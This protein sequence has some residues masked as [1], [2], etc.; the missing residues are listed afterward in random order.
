MNSCYIPIM[1]SILGFCLFFILSSSVL[2]QSQPQ[3]LK[4]KLDS[5][6]AHFSPKEPG[7]SILIRE[8][9]KIIYQKSFGLEDLGTRKKFS[10]RTVSNT[11]SI[12]KTFVAY[13]ILILQEQGKLSL[14]DPLDKFFPD[15]KNPTIARKIMVRHLLTHTSGL[16]D[17]RTVSRDS[18]FYLSAKDEENFAPLKQTDSLEFEPGS[19]WKYS[20]PA[21]N[22]LALI[23]EKITGER[24][25]DFIQREIFKK[26]G[27]KDSRITLGSYPDQDVAHGYRK[28]NGTFREYDYGEYPTFAAA[29]NGGV[30]SSIE[31]LDRY[32]HAMRSCSFLSCAGIRLSQTVWT[33]SNWTSR[34]PSRQGLS[35]FLEEPTNPGSYRLIHH[36]GSQGGF[37]ADLF[38]VPEPDIVIIWLTN[39]NQ[40]LTNTIMKVMLELKYLR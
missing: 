4:R 9:G 26:A 23:I 28:I 37:R 21:F 10:A 25:Q 32:V 27:M 13:G 22:G 24:W 36:S 3:L 39:N 1:H 19:N 11:G 2:A 31:D 15:F 16:P 7:G 17:S 40:S 8:K 6:F 30:W 5:A 34:Q 33:P 38:I 18:I 14:D 12:S 20:N 29:G 35:W